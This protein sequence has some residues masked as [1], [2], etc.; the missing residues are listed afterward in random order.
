MKQHE[1]LLAWQRAAPRRLRNRARR[2][3]SS[4]CCG[5]TA[6]A[7]IIIDLRFPS[8]CH[9]GYTGSRQRGGPAASLEAP[10]R[11][12]SVDGKIH[13]PCTPLS[14][15]ASAYIALC[16]A[17]HSSSQDNFFFFFFNLPKVILDSFIVKN[18]EP[19]ALLRKKSNK[20]NSRGT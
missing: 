13:L 12:S 15:M 20:E 7:I 18:C 9:A 2:L 8:T 6:P 17:E 19:Q 1:R 4:T 16:T 14:C 5:H 3:V 10:V 11:L